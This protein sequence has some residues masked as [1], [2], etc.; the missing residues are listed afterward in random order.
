[1]PPEAVNIGPRL[2]RPMD[3]CDRQTNGGVSLLRR[4]AAIFAAG[5]GIL[6]NA[7]RHP[8]RRNNEIN[9]QQ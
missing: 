9:P 8:H 2:G 3:G 6:R 1:M 5:V 7:Q 4:L